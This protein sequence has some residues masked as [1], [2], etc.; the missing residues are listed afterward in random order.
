MKRTVYAFAV[1]TLIFAGAFGASG[2][3]PI[4]PLTRIQ[5][6]ALIQVYSH[7]YRH[8]HQYIVVPLTPHYGYPFQYYYWRRDYLPYWGP[9][10]YYQSPFELR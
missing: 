3:T 8:S 6:S 1:A 7:H 4:A 9:Q 2:A 10:G 5:T